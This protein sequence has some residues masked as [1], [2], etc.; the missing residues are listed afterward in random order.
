MALSAGFRFETDSLTGTQWAAVVLAFLTGLI[1]LFVGVNRGRP[2]LALAGVGFGVGIALFLAAHRRHMLYLVGS[3][4]V[5]LQI[6]L[7]IVFQQGEYTPLGFLD[8]AI[9]I[10]LVALLL[11]LA[12]GED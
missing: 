8:K 4:Y 3:V 12:R 9:Q 5:A 7:W 2:S 1:H 6:V 11:A 10:L